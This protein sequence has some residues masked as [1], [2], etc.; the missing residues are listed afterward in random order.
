MI[1][2][3]DFLP[4]KETRRLTS[5]LCV[6]ACV[7]VRVWSPVSTFE[8]VDRCTLNLAG[9]YSIDET[10]QRSTFHFPTQNSKQPGHEADH[11]TNLIQRFRMSGAMPQLPIMPS[12]ALRGSALL[13]TE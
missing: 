9:V 8:A 5:L 11:H 4:E 3:Y 2:C 12:V 10:L 7:R 6:R 13:Y 1:F